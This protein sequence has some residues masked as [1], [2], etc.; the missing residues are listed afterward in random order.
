MKIKIKNRIATSKK[1]TIMIPNF[2]MKSK[3]IWK[4]AI[5]NC[6]E[7]AKEEL[8]KIEPIVS[9]GYKT[10]KK[11]IKINGHFKLVE[12]ESEQAYITI[13]L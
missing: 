7:E 13:I 10:L 8:L 12:V 6:D 9:E 1:I 3:L 5:K 4:I 11:V 2:L